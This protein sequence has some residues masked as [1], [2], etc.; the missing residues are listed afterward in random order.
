M[1]AYKLTPH[2]LRDMD[3]AVSYRSECNMQAGETLAVSFL[4]SFHMLARF[5]SAGRK[6]PE[7]TAHDLR[8]WAVDQYF[9]VYMPDTSPLQMVAVLHTS[10]DVQH[11]LSGRFEQTGPDTL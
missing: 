8:F 1:N 4:D 3:D 10:R 6:R 9:V 2:A 7:F 11:L 5:P